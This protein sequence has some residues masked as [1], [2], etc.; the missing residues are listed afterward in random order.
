[1]SVLICGMECVTLNRV[2]YVKDDHHI[3][4][5]RIAPHSNTYVDYVTFL[6]VP[7]H[8]HVL[9]CAAVH[10]LFTRKMIV[11]ILTSFVFINK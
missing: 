7:C 1:M 8:L 9:A 11:I 4:W 3:N 5:C 6:R 10:N 2:G